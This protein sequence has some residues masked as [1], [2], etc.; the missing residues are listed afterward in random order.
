MNAPRPRLRRQG[1]FSLIELISAFAIMALAMGVFM[2]VTATSLRA[3]QRS[4]DFTQAALW[5][6][7][8][9]DSLGMGE[10]LREQSDSGR[11]DDKFDFVLDVRKLEAPPGDPTSTVVEQVPVDLFRVELAVRW[12]EGRHPREMKFV[13]MRAVQPNLDGSTR[14]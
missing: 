12:D 14:P 6:Q 7:S 9:L 8:K 5:A 13:T 1:G 2:E 4:S 3:A 10:P 11:F